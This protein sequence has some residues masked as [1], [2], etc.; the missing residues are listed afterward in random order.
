MNIEVQ[1]ASLQD[2]LGA[3][4]EN[5]TT[6]PAATVR[7]WLNEVDAMN[8]QFSELSSAFQR[9]SNVNAALALMVQLLDSAHAE[10]FDADQMF[11]LIDPLRERL[12]QAI[13]EVQ[14]AI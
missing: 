3:S 12:E 10:K 13:D 11:C 6:V 5:E 9:I 1:L 8:V 2:S 14:L 7:K 4:L